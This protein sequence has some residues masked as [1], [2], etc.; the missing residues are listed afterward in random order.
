MK[1]NS[2]DIVQNNIVKGVEGIQSP[3][4]GVGNKLGFIEQKKIIEV[5]GKCSAMRSSLKYATYEKEYFTHIDDF[6]GSEAHEDFD[7]LMQEFFASL[8]KIGE[9]WAGLLFGA[10]DTIER[11]MFLIDQSLRLAKSIKH[12]ESTLAMLELLTGV[13][14]NANEL[15]SNEYGRRLLTLLIKNNETTVV[16]SYKKI[17]GMIGLLQNTDIDEKKMKKVVFEVNKF[18]ESF[19]LDYV[20]MNYEG[21]YFIEVSNAEVNEARKMITATGIYEK[22]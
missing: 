8:K 14:R 3:R 21:E 12:D 1:I 17:S 9:G 13:K 11:D 7:G 22:E 15:F 20:D 16:E 6:M 19:T 4:K 10:L 18:I 2:Y 5:I